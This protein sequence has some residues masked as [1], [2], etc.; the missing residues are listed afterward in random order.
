MDIP[1]MID[2]RIMACSQQPPEIAG[3]WFRQGRPAGNVIMVKNGKSSAR[4]KVGEYPQVWLLCVGKEKYGKDITRLLRA[5]TVFR[6]IGGIK[7]R[8]I[9][10]FRIWQIS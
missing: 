2:D 7:G 10:H 8:G 5:G 1:C 9:P 4:R 3:A 6:T